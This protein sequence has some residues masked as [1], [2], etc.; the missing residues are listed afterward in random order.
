MPATSKKRSTSGRKTTR[1]QT[2]TNNRS[3]MDAISLLTKDHG[4]VRQL[5]KRLE[6]STENGGGDSGELLRQVENELKIHTQIEEE[7]FYPAF[8]D[9]VESEHDQKLYYEA[10]EEHHV[11]DLVMPE[12]KSSRKNSDEFS[13]KAKVLKDLVE[14]HAEE[15]ETEMFPKARKA[16][17]AA[18]LRELGQRLKERKQELMGGK[19][20]SE[21]TIEKVLRPFLSSERNKRRRVA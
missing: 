1:R 20:T 3:G 4:T 15:E 13:A 19:R 21:S 2:G 7:I 12:I 8:R 16:L 9:A 17:G 18:E 14:H 5:L 10:F 6:S 11:V